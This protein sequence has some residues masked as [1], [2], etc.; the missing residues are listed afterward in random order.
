MNEVLEAEGVPWAVY[1]EHSFF[2]IHS[3]PR[4]DAIRPTAFDASTITIDA[5]KGKNEPMLGKLRLAMLNNGVDLKGTRGGI[6]SAAHTEADVELTL[7]AWRKAL[8]ALREEGEL[9]AAGLSARV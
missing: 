6:V 8:R 5:L 4:G 2:H 1:G 3:N 9:V 7:H